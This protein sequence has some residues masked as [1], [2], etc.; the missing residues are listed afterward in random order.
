M[1]NGSPLRVPNLCTP[2]PDLI[3][4]GM[5]G[6]EDLRQARQAGIKT[7]INLCQPQEPSPEE[8]RLP[9]ELGMGYHNIPVGGAADLTETKARQLAAIVNDCN[10]HPVLIHCMSGN[11]VGAL[12]AMKTFYADGKSA[13]ESLQA[14]R[15]AGLKGLEPEVVR[16][17]SS[18]P[19]R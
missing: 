10:N 6:P 3:T 4:C 12:L 5:P 2:S 7:I 11:R 14:G 1:F 19:A 18:Q 8:P 13:Q 15:A 9:A 16:I 17:L